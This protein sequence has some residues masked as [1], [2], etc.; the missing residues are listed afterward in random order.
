MLV[1]NYTG[2]FYWKN[3]IP[4]VIELATD[5]HGTKLNKARKNNDLQSIT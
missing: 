1:H 3:K 4:Q 5:A 2:F